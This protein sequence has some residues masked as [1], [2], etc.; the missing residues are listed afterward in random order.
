[1]NDGG[2]LGLASLAITGV[3]GVLTLFINK[4][5][6]KKTFDLENQ[7]K[8]QAAQIATLTA[9]TSKCKEEHAVKD[10][11]LAKC[12]EKHET[13]EIRLADIEARLKDEAGG[14]SSR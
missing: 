4:R 2:V 14:S 7:N 11:K 12:E 13:M 3:L 6:D 1:M 9:D 5:Y 8:T 10:A